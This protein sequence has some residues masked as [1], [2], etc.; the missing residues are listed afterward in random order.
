MKA[1]AELVQAVAALLWPVSLFVILLIFRRP[2]QDLL[3]RLRRGKVLGQEIELAEFTSN[4]GS[5]VLASSA[6]ISK[7]EE[8]VSS[9][10]FQ[11]EL[12]NAVLYR[13]RFTGHR[14]DGN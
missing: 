12:N 4:R 8:L 2:I 1:W 5:Q 10:E 14:V 13:P 7:L 9:K 3:S 11:A 6:V